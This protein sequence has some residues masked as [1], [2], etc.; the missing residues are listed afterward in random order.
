MPKYKIVYLV[1]QYTEPWGTERVLALKANFLVQNGYEV[2]IISIQDTGNEP[3]YQFDPAIEIIELGIEDKPKFESLFIDQL[4]GVLQKINPTVVITTLS[5]LSTHLHRVKHPCIKVAEYHFSKFKGK[6]KLA[7]I[8]QFKA[9]QWIPNFIVRERI[10]LAKQYDHFIVLTDED[11]QQW[12]GLP[13]LRVIKNMVTIEPEF[14]KDYGAKQ[15]IGIGR[16]SR[17][18]GW[19]YLVKIWAKLAPDYP[20]WKVVIYGDGR[21]QKEL[22]KMIRDRGIE[23]SFKLC[24]LSQEVPK[25]ISESS[26]IVATSRYEGLPLVLLEA[27][28]SGLA[29]ITF[30]YKCG[31]KDII[32][33]GENGFITSKFSIN[34]FA[35]QLKVLM[36]SEELREKMGKQA[37]ESAKAYTPNAIMEQWIRFFDELTQTK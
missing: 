34:E 3:F 24:G 4:E 17:Q 6:R 19:D 29:P 27:M 26:I 2:S 1:S 7:Y 13:N 37:I 30:P 10:R 32:N 22:E 16:L 15:I 8:N 31:P 5:G 20:D 9:L 33:S 25:H 12:N 23:E 36:D 14:V 35:Q 21:K 18:K 11:L 28:S